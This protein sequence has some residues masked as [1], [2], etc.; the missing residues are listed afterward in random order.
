MDRIAQTKQQ[1]STKPATATAMPTTVTAEQAPPEGAPME[2]DDGKHQA[3]KR[4]AGE[5]LG[6]AASSASQAGA[7]DPEAA[8]A[9]ALF[10][11]RKAGLDESVLKQVEDVVPVNQTTLDKGK[12]ESNS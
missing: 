9:Q 11:I 6:M 3:V 12:P 5:E 8:K 2:Q 4:G 1:Q 7:E 10:F